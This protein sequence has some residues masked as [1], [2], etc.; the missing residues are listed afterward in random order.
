LFKINAFGGPSSRVQICYQW[1][2][3]GI[4]VENFSDFGGIFSDFG[5][6]IICDHSISAISL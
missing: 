2:L 4:L 6:K 3:N 5:N 1:D